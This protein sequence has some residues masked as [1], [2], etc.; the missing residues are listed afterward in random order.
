MVMQTENLTILNINLIIII[1]I[2]WEVTK[3]ENSQLREIYSYT[4]DPQDR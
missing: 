4:Y 1:I 3:F 2:V